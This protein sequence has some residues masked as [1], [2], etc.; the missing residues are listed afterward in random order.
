MTIFQQ[1]FCSPWE[2]AFPRSRDFRPSPGAVG[3]ELRG[4]P[5][6][7]GARQARS[8]VLRHSA[9]TERD[10]PGTGLAAVPSLR[11]RSLHGGH[12]PLLRPRGGWVNPTPYQEH[13]ILCK[14]PGGGGGGTSTLTVTGT[15]RWTGYDFAIIT[16]DTGYLNRHNWLLADYSVYHRVASQPTMFMTDPRSRHQRWCVRDATDFYECKLSVKRNLSLVQ[17]YIHWN[18]LHQNDSYLDTY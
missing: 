2:D 3:A 12:L 18:S 7:D 10:L 16:I 17:S 5:P 9:G 6:R 8:A 14:S 11:L 13:C 15:C 1:V 4:S